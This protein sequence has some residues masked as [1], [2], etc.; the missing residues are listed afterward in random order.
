[1][2]L[3]FAP[4][5]GPAA[6]VARAVSWGLVAVLA[7]GLF[8]FAFNQLHYGWNWPAI[9][10]YRQKFLQG[11]LMTV[12][13]SASALLVSLIIGL[14]TALAGLDDDAIHAPWQARP[15]E[16]LA[17]GVELGR[18]YP[19]PVVDHDEARARTLARFEAVKKVAA[20]R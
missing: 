14:L 3:L 19:Q 8:S 1:M 9:W 2:N 7:A 16:R 11:W 4:S 20:R 10:T 18:T 15:M 5:R 12:A 6:R 13:I 17:A